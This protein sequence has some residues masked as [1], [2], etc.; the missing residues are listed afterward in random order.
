MFIVSF[1][2]KELIESFDAVKAINILPLRGFL[3]ENLPSIYWHS[4]NQ[5][6]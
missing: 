1:A 2:N 5:K 3:S 6:L 4:R